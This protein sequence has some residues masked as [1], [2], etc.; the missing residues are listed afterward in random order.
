MDAT[1]LKL[2]S[3]DEPQFRRKPIILGHQISS[4]KPALGFSGE[5]YSA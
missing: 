5:G 3:G 1:G 4:I 2:T